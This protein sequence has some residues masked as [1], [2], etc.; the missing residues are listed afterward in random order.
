MRIK[1]NHLSL[2]LFPETV[3]VCREKEEKYFR[4]V[5]ELLENTHSVKTEVIV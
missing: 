3:I 1:V 4:Q 2:G 5:A